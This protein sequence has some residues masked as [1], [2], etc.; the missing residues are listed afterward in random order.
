MTNAPD[1]AVIAE[2]FA[3]QDKEKK[4]R[5]EKLPTLKINEELKNYLDILTAEERKGLEKDLIDDGGARD[6]IVVWKETGEIVDGHNRYDIC[7][8]NGLPFKTV[9][10]SFKDIEAAKAWMLENQLHRRNLS[11]LRATY[12]LGLLYNKI[13]QTDPARKETG[14]GKTTAEKLAEQFSVS[15]RTV[16]RAGEAANGIEAIGKAHG[17]QSVKD[18]IAQI[19]DRNQ[20]N[21]TKQELEEIGKIPDPEVA[22]EAVKELDKIKAQEKK[23]QPKK[24]KAT[25]NVT[26]PKAT[27][28]S[29]AL[30]A[31]A[32]DGL[33]FS[34]TTEPKP[35]LAENAAV[36]MVAPDEELDKAFKLIEKWGLKYEGSI[37]FLTDDP[38]EGTF[39]DVRHMNVLVACRGVVTISGKA[40]PSVIAKSND[41]EEAMLKIING[42]HPNAKKI[43]MRK[44]RNP[45]GWDKP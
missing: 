8:A 5:A 13:K 41:I 29:V 7:K 38:Y 17:V 4:E 14:D 31:P 6:P 1:A 21:Y 36:Y 32:F 20:I 19:R 44:N 28:Y 15:E 24:E 11:P 45:A 33:S 12:F 16:R 25:K 2:T 35:A 26:K 10:R 22:V 18:K 3:K 39:T 40:S 30:C 9:E 37:V 34:L 27:V 43:D 23:T 42:Y